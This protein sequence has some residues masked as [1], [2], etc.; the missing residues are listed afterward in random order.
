MIRPMRLGV[1]V[2]LIAAWATTTVAQSCTAGQY[3]PLGGSAPCTSCSPGMYMP[4]QGAT[5]CTSCAA[6][7][8]LTSTGATASTSCASCA[9]GSFATASGAV[10]S[11]VCIA[12]AAGNYAE[13]V[14]STSCTACAA[15]T[16]QAQT[17]AMTSASCEP[18]ATGFA[19]SAV[20]SASC[21]VC[22]AGT[23]ASS[24]G[25]TGCVACPAGTYTATTGSTTGE[26]CFSVPTHR[27]DFRG[28]IDGS[29]VRDTYSEA[30]SAPALEATVVFGPA[31]CSC[32]GATLDGG[33]SYIALNALKLGANFT[34]EVFFSKRG[35]S[36]AQ[37]PPAPAGIFDFGVD[38]F[39]TNDL[40]LAVDNIPGNVTASCE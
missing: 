27:W 20:A 14:G 31:A 28:C 10:V 35:V 15:G 16:Y 4:T 36:S 7:F 11:D 6:G 37:V 21:T 26:T 17:G 24:P 9:A 23:F 30:Y 25:S 3:S 5:S 40:L 22:A 18:C 32:L 12:C 19:S 8:Y 39:Y 1:H 13:F 29:P 34:V 2:A 38:S 33:N